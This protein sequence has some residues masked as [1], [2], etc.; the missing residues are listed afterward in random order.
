[1]KYILTDIEG[2]TSSISFVHEVLFPYAYDRMDSFVSSN[3]DSLQDILN[4]IPGNLSEKIST[5]KNW[6]KT[7]KKEKVLK[8]IQGLIWE[9]GY[10]NGEIKGHV[11]PEVSDCLKSWL[12]SGIKLGV[13]SSGSI[14]AQKLLFKY[15]VAG[16]L[17]QYFSHNF[18]TNVGHKR[19][20][21]AY[22]NILKEINHKASDV[23]FLSDIK[24]EL[25]AAAACG[26]NTIQLD[27]LNALSN[28][29][30]QIVKNFTEIKF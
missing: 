21:T 13:Y 30:H 7:D 12:N 27:R 1:M 25:D 8:D 19:E 16:D 20:V 11:Y 5:L 17:D 29:G 24:E 10:L 14:K 22:E 6:I 18:D 2:T 23:L 28:T 9:K 4:T 15:S 3:Q 26:I